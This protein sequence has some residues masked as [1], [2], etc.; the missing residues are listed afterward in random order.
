MLSPGEGEKGV[1]GKE[2]SRRTPLAPLRRPTTYRPPSPSRWSGPVADCRTLC[3]CSFRF[4]DNDLGW[5]SGEVTSKEISG[6]EGE[7]VVDLQFVDEAGKVRLPSVPFCY[8]AYSADEGTL[9]PSMVQDHSLSLALAS[10]TPSLS[11]P[12]SQLPPL[13]NPPLLESQEDLANLSNLNEP[14]VLHA[15]RTRYDMHLPYTYSG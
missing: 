8:A 14:S 9:G 6:A 10:L 15:I 1:S 7:E 11:S 4:P 13:K 5:I 3:I 12:S 2:R